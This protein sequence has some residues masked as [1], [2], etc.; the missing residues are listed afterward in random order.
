MGKQFLEQMSLH[1]EGSL[2]NQ[3]RKKRQQDDIGISRCDP[4]E[5]FNGA[6]LASQHAVNTSQNQHEHCIWHHKIMA[7]QLQGVFGDRSNNQRQENVQNFCN[8]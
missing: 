2:I 6:G 1:R 3:P 5:Y 8:N 4:D 7:H